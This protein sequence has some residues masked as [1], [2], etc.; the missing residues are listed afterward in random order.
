MTVDLPGM[1]QK[2]GRGRPRKA[3]AMTNAERQA[4]FRARRKAEQPTDRSVTVT[5]KVAEVDAYDDCQEQV[6]ALRFELAETVQAHNQVV[7][8]LDEARREKDIAWRV[9]REQRDKA[10]E[11]GREVLQLKK[12][13]LQDKSVTPSNGNPV[14]FETMLDLIA[15][16]AKANTFEQRQKVRDMELWVESFVRSQLVSEAQMEAAGEAI[17]GDRKVVTRQV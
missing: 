4:A 12:R 11:L 8:Q 5:K 1:E 15:L 2:R 7:A 3:H 17:Y 6:D 13:L 9:M 10:E 14:S 16:A